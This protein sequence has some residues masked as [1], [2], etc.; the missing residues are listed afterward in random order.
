MGA[1]FTRF[2]HDSRGSEQVTDG[3]KPLDNAVFYN[4]LV[5]RLI[6]FLGTRTRTGQLYEVDT[7]LRPSGRKGLLVTSLDAFERYQTENAWTWEHQALLRAR[8][9]AGTMTVRDAFEQIRRETLSSRVHRDSL[10][11]DV[12]DMRAKMRRELDRSDART[13]DLKQGEG[14]IGDIEFIVQ[15]LVL[16]QAGETATVIEHSDNIRQLDALAACGALAGAL[17]ADLQDIYRRYR[18]RQHRLVLNN[19]KALVP[20]AEFEA[21]RATVREAWH[22]VFGA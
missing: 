19:R 15:F 13:F 6:H 20:S 14:G 3:E 18:R 22:T 7:R 4:R 5:R 1:K 11:D 9:V 12:Q 21:E 2:V 17:A 16:R 10:R 8:A